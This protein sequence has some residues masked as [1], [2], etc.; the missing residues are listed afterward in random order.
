MASKLLQ[1]RESQRLSFT[2]PT[3]P[4]VY[5]IICTYPGHWRRMYSA[6]YVVSDLE[7]YQTAPD[8]YLVAHP[9]AVKDAMLKDRRPRTEWKFSDLE[10]M[11]VD[12]KPGRSFGNGKQMFKVA[13]CVACHKFDGQ[14]NSFA[15][16]LTQ[17]DPKW[18]HADLVKN[19]VEPS[20]Q[21]NEKFQTW[22]F[23]M[24]DGKTVT[25]LIL[26]EK[27]DSY[28]VI[29]NPL[30]KAEPIVLKK[31]DVEQKQKSNVS[32]MPK[33]LLD[34]LSRDEILDLLAYIISKGKP[35][36]E[37]FKGEKHGH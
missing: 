30:L 26:E 16:D 14:G 20:F 9:L 34:T 7:G 36:H 19:I 11:L 23:A 31:A 4:G 21:I 3:A 2:A 29:E 24:N 32:T 13:S 33:G 15:P 6:L 17:L 37:L 12:L 27:P 25:G 18:T 5:P 8:A 28:K 35:E 22:I 10:P 1:P